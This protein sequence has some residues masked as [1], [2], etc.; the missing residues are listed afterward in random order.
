MLRFLSLVPVEYGRGVRGG[1]VAVD[2]E[3][4]EAISFQEAASAAFADVQGELEARD[5]VAA[6]RA[7][8]LFDD[9]ATTSGVLWSGG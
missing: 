1:E 9:L 4:R 7:T 2:L 5:A 8:A 3:I 6:E